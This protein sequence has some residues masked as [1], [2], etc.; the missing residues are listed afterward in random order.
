MITLTPRAEQQLIVLHALDRGELL[1]AKAAGLLGLSTRQVRR[2]RRAYRQH[3]PT[4]LVH[5]NRGRQSPRR[6]REAIRKR[7]VRLARTTYAGVNHK[8]LTELLAEREGLTLSHPTIHRILRAAGLRSPRRRRPPRHRRRRERMP[9]AGLLV[10]VDGSTHAWLDHRGPRLT[11]IAA[12]DDAT[13]EVLGATF[14]DQEDAHGY[15]EVF[16][17]LTQAKGIPVAV[18]SDRHGI[19]HRTIKR[20]LTLQEQ[21]A[22]KPAPTQVA[23]ALQELGTRWIPAR[24]PQAKGRIERLFGTFQDRLRSELRLAGVRDRARANAFLAQFLPRY[25]ARFT[26]APAD[27]TPAYRPWPAELDPQTIFCF[28]YQRV[29][30]NDNT[31]MLGPQCIQLLP[32]PGGRSYAKATVEVHERRDGSIAVFYRGAR[33]PCRRLTAVTTADRI[34]AR[35]HP[36]VHPDPAYGVRVRP[37]GGIAIATPARK[38]HLGASERTRLMTNS[39]D[40]AKP[41]QLRKPP[42]PDHPWRHMPV[43]KAKPRA[44]DP[45]RTKSLNA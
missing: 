44:S 17:V 23:R 38:T 6:V 32:G 37:G 10:Q 22:G 43:G 21:L 33:L 2:L 25:N 13:G 19:F 31:L 34:P 41:V 5:G 8:H 20:P 40:R 16:H 30:S 45:E 15:F 11:L 4:A 35:I 27:P 28:K 3:G 18:Y 12:I 9:Q 36:R 29:V 14:R 24:S 7:I 1:M 26:Q 39:D 42:A